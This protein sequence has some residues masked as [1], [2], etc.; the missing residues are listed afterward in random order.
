MKKFILSSLFFTA[1]VYAVLAAGQ[2]DVKVATTPT[3]RY[4]PT[5][6]PNSW[7]KRWLAK[8]TQINQLKNQIDIV[9]IGD[10][11]THFWERSG[12]DNKRSLG[13]IN[14]FNNNFGKY[15]VLNIGHSGDCTQHTL[16]MINNSQLLDNIKPQLA[17]VM[18]GTNNLGRRQT[19]EAAVA[20]IKCVIS[21]LRKKL[22]E[23]KILL[24]GVF[25]RGAKPDNPFRAKIKTINRSICSLADDRNVFYCDITDQLLEKDG[26]L[27][28][29]IMP[30]FLH[31]SEVGYAIWA[32]AIMPY[33]EKFVK[34][35][36]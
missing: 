4:R 30:D 18:I 9:F 10:S 17:V 23:C 31:P 27:S 11:I 1:A 6:Q 14:T 35:K 15:N 12:K 22:P 2:I 24:F 21:E 16:W 33:V 29:Q 28:P 3:P 32:K 20:G 7:H 5:A 13:G 19:P 25:P 26:S 34:S 8:K 36:K